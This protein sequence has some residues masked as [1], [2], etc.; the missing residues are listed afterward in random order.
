MNKNRRISLSVRKYFPVLMPCHLAK[1]KRKKNNQIKAIMIC[2][3]SEC[4][5]MRHRA[6]EN[7]VNFVVIE[8]AKFQCVCA[9]LCTRNEK[10]MNWL[11]EHEYL[12]LCI[13]FGKKNKKHKNIICRRMCDIHMKRTL[14][15]P[16]PNSQEKCFINKIENN[17]RDK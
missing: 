6:R 15:I 13:N 11:S 4:L 3:I 9:N 16:Q 17:N 1:T 12:F 10:R 7:S 14:T 5:C 8:S 2:S